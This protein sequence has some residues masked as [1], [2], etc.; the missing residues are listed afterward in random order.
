[1]S[2]CQTRENGCLHSPPA[3]WGTLAQIVADYRRSRARRPDELGWFHE[4][5]S[6]SE[7]LLAAATATGCGEKRFPHQRRLKRTALQDAH[8]RLAAGARELQ[9]CS[10]FDALH[11]TIIRL[12]A[13]VHGIG[14]L[15]HYDTALRL[16]AYLGQYPLCVY[17]H[18]GTREG[19]CALLPGIKGDRLE[20]QDLPPALRT[21]EPY[22]VEDVLCIYKKAIAATNGR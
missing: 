10:S 13:G 22:Q 7:A 15:Y 5:T 9:I 16:G 2:S 19:A 4:R 1:M 8:R 14:A 12:T 3:R 17:L 11:Q 21:L 6:F 18:A 20:L